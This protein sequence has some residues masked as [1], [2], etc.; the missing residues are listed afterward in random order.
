[1]YSMATIEI[2]VVSL[3]GTP[4]AY[5]EYESENWGVCDCD[6]GNQARRFTWSLF[7]FFSL[8]LLLC[9]IAVAL[10]LIF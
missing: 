10:L 4:K 3:S 1:M 7:I 9:T 5:L 6:Y 2:A 8:I